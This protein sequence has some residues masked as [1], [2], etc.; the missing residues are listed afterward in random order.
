[1]EETTREWQDHISPQ[2]PIQQL[3]SIKLK[4]KENAFKHIGKEK[5]RKQ[6]KPWVSEEM[7]LEID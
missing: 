5:R 3:E 6:K 7:I 2:D 1:M 4:I